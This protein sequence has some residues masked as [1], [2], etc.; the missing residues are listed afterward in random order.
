MAHNAQSASILRQNIE[1]ALKKNQVIMIVAMLKDKDHERFLSNLAPCADIMC[2]AGLD[3][4]RG[5]TGRELELAAETSQMD[6]EVMVFDRILDALSWAGTHAL[7]DDVIVITGSF[8][9]VGMAIEYF[10]LENQ[11]I[12]TTS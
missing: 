10:N 8:I 3:T 1:K 11:H 4:D 2:L 9:T 6:T 7:T 5:A 12:G